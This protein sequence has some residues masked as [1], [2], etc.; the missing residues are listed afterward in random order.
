LDI[1]FMSSVRGKP[2]GRKKI[3]EEAWILPLIQMDSVCI[4]HGKR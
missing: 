3:G 4:D 2:G 1:I